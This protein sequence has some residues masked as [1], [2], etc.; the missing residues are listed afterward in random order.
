MASAAPRNFIVPVR[1]VRVGFAVYFPLGLSEPMVDREI[2]WFL[3][4]LIFK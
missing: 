3:R 4:K 1:V 2:P